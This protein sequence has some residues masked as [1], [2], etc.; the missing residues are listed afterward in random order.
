MEAG[1]AEQESKVFP[2]LTE[3]LMLKSDYGFT[4]ELPVRNQ[5]V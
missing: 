2:E 4:T 1:S 5:T 3:S